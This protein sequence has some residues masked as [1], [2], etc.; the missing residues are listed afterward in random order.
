MAKRSKSK[1]RFYFGYGAI[2]QRKLKNGKTRWYMDYRDVNNKRIQRVAKKAQSKEEALIELQEE[3][4]KEFNKE[5]GIKRD[6][7]C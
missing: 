3:V 1:T 4:A 5:Y 6:V 7:F 2:Y